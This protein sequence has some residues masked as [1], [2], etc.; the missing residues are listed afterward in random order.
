MQLNR[1]NDPLAYGGFV[2]NSIEKVRLLSFVALKWAELNLV[3]WTAE[4]KFQAETMYRNNVA[5]GSYR[6]TFSKQFG[7]GLS[8]FE[9]T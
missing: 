6:P 8:G 7:G 9:E 4:S 3:T 2:G 5:R 1:C